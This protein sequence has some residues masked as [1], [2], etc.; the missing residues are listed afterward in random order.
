[1]ILL[2]IDE[3]IGQT[4]SVIGCLS[5]PFENLLKYEHI[6]LQKRIEHKCWAE[7]SW[8]GISETYLAKYIDF[9][10]TYL[11]DECVTF[12]SKYKPE[13]LSISWDI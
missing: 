2:C 5:F 11:S 10:V 7:L 13:V 6:L 12:H 9:L 1:M 3:S 8:D 4:N